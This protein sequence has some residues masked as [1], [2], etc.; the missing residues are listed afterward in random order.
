MDDNFRL[1]M[2]EIE[3]CKSDILN[4]YK[5][6]IVDYENLRQLYEKVIKGYEDDGNGD[7]EVV[8]CSDIVAENLSFTTT[9]WALYTSDGTK[10][11]ESGKKY[12]L[13][14]W[15]YALNRLN[16][17]DGTPI[18]AGTQLI[19]KAMVV[20]GSDSTASVILEYNPL[21]N[22]TAMFELKGTAFNTT[23]HFISV[24]G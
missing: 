20:S 21:I 19:L 4:D 5:N 8:Q 6:L 12:R 3:K 1:Y 2:L 24:V 16:N 22:A 7:K 17:T 14:T 11:Y 13:Q 10:L 23:L 9:H 15:D 18:A